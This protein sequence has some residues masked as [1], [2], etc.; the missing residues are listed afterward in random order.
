[1]MSFF[2]GWT[3][4]AIVGP[5]NKKEVRTAL[6]D[7]GIE[8][9]CFRTWDT[10]EQ[11]ILNSSDEVKKILYESGVSKRIVEEQHRSATLK[12]RREERSMRRIVRQ[13]IG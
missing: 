3:A 13:R 12:R 7:Y 6:L 8:R 4:H 2:D 5:L 9:L 10:I 1:M 11:M